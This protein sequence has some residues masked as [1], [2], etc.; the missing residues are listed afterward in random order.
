M[1]VTEAIRA[2]RSTRAFKEE[3]VPEEA[4]EAILDAARYAPSA[5]NS[6]HWR[7]ILVR[8]PEARGFMADLCEHRAKATFGQIPFELEQE[9]LWYMPPEIR[10]DILERSASGDVFRYAEEADVAIVCCY[11]HAHQDVP[12]HN[13]SYESV[14]AGIS[15]AIQNMW[16]TAHKLGLGAGF[17]VMPGLTDPRIEELTEEY[18][19][20]P[21]SW[22]V[23]GVLCIGH[24]R[25]KRGL[26]PSRFPLESIV[27]TE[28]WGMPYLRRA[29]RD[30]EGS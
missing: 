17:L 27:Y 3:P 10:P 9:R 23:F 28:R 30:L 1:D 5:E 20:L 26:A 29:L 2:R 22:R 4:V 11:S 21:R 6:Q 19:G 18:F 16:L 12:I 14:V 7:F 25:E 15:M 13:T 8:D 24:P